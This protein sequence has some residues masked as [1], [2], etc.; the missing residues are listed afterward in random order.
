MHRMRRK[1]TF[2]ANSVSV[3]LLSIRHRSEGTFMSRIRPAGQSSVQ[4]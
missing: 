1:K 4:S 3:K 2:S